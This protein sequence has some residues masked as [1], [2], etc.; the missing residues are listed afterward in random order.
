[1]P[2]DTAVS[3]W[4]IRTLLGKSDDRVTSVLLILRRP[5]ITQAEIA[6]SLGKSKTAAGE[7][8][9]TLARDGYIDVDRTGTSPTYSLTPG[10]EQLAVGLET[11]ARESPIQNLV[12]R[13]L[14][15]A[16]RAPASSGLD[17]SRV[18][19]RSSLM[20]FAGFGDFQYASICEDN[21][22]LVIE[23]LGRIEELRGE[24]SALRISATLPR[25]A[26]QAGEGG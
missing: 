18:L 16:K 1:M 12:G 13:V 11:L 25:P 7:M 10:T 4:S 26:A 9:E 19:A 6:R 8:L 3:M 5:G 22:A 14:V 15:V 21:P 23:L 17:V 2:D 20:A 24:A